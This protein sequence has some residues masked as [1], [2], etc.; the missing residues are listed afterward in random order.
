MLK[1]KLNP[2]SIP[3]S[4]IECK[5]IYSLERF[6]IVQEELG[7]HPPILIM[8]SLLGVQGFVMMYSEQIWSNNH[9]IEHNNLILPDIKLQS[10]NY[11]AW[12]IMKPAF[13]MIWNAVGILSS[14]NYNENGKPK[15]GVLYG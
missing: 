14:I 9:P 11:N 8:L 6:I 4:V 10:F 7:V 3:I 12:E 5:I 2:P 15:D 13:D 1:Y